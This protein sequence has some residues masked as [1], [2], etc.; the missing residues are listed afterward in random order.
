MCPDCTEAYDGPGGSIDSGLKCQTAAT[1]QD[2]T[3]A[4][5]LIPLA[6]VF[7]CFLISL[8]IYCY[9]KQRRPCQNKKKGANHNQDNQFG[10]YFSN[11]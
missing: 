11:N 1:T 3:L 2:T 4:K 9:I 8:G 7:V 6:I 5:I 10:M